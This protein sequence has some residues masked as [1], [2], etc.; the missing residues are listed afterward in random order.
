MATAAV[1]PRRTY[2][3]RANEVADLINKICLLRSDADRW[4]ETRDAAA[5]AARK[6]ALALDADG[7]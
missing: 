3:Q 2:A 6:L 7:L 1:A 5:R 4:H